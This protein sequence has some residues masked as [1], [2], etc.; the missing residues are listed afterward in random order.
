[1]T[2]RTDRDEIHRTAPAYWALRIAL[3]VVPIVAGLDKFTN[4]LAD[5]AG[6]LSPLAVRLLPVSPAA[7]MRA[8]G[9]IEVIVGVG[10][11]SGRARTFGWIAMAW[12]AAIALNLIA[13]GAFL[14]VAARDAVMAVAAFALARL[15]A[16]H[17]PV[18]AR[19]A[20]AVEPQATAAHPAAT[21]P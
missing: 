21:R 2:D 3:G 13:S 14:D 5:W 16:V 20:T 4:L 9:V 8:A 19:R 6:Y 17:E 18:R 15:A 1:M 11:L 12:L 7:F 10:I